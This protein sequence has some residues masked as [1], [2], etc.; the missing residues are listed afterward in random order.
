MVGIRSMPGNPYDEHTLEDAIE[1]VCILANQ[2][3]RTVKGYKG[4]EV[5]GVPGQ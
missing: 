2:R 1:Q 4:A 3:P 5:E